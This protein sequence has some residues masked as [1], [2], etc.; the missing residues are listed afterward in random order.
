MGRIAAFFDIDGT[1]YREGLIS[2]LFK[3]F[4]RYELI[5]EEVWRN[6]VEPAYHR[7]VRREGDY[8]TY[9]LKMI[10]IFIGAIKGLSH[11][12]VDY[13]ASRVINQ[14]GDRVYT[15][16]RDRIKW[17]REQGHVIIAISGSPYEL[18]SNMA[19]KY[20]MDD[21]RGT[22]YELDEKGRYTGDIIPMWD[23]ESKIKAMTNLQQKYDI[24][25]SQSYAYGDTTGD[26][27]MFDAV[28]YPYAIN[29]TNELLAKI[30]EDPDLRAKINV[31]VE[32]KDVRYKIDL[33]HTD[34]V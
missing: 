6:E 24:D 5:E 7:W 10:E 11:E 14:K 12:H 13:V 18:V 30:S 27:T 4:L 2:E 34:L 28:G 9:L 33:N 20:K 25:L 19:K 15:F 23:S 21:F 22:I 29:P 17:H 8:D 31:I 1:I 16:S 32:R 3:K 26:L